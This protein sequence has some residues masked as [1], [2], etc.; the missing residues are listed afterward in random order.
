MGRITISYDDLVGLDPA[1]IE[2]LR[3]KEEAVRKG[4]TRIGRTVSVR[5][6]P[7][8]AAQEHLLF[9]LTAYSDRADGIAQFSPLD[10]ALDNETFERLIVEGNRPCP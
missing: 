7:V 9:R 4:I 10:L 1:Y 8:S 6:V 2:K 5:W 3:G